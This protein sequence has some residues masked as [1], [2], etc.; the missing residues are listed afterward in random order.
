MTERLFPSIWD[1]VMVC[2]LCGSEC[3]LANAEAD[4]DGDGSPGCPQPD[5]GGIL[6]EK[7]VN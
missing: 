6:K 5:C 4:V 3:L 2:P 1:V 7:P